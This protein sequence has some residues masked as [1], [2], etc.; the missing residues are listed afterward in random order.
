MSSSESNQRQ[1]DFRCPV[2]RARQKLSLQCRRC[3]AD[4]ALVYRARNRLA[5]LSE[6]PETPATQAEKRLLAPGGDA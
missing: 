1:Q 4:L 3:K 2:C 6:L 5:H